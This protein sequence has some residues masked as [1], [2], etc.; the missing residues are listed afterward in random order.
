M[1]VILR[2]WRIWDRHVY[3]SKKKKKRKKE[4]KDA[5]PIAVD[6]EVSTNAFSVFREQNTMRTELPKH[7]IF[8]LTFFNSILFIKN[9]L[10]II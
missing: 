9:H 1:F 7:G 4:K 5:V 3:Q 10:L 6:F 8:I 2:V